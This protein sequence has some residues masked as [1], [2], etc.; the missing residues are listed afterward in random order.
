MN[1]MTTILGVAGT[2]A[3]MRTVLVGAAAAAVAAALALT[4]AWCVAGVC[5]PAREL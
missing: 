3:M 5:R 1:D 4:A 2:T